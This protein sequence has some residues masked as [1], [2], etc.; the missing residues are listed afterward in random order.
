MMIMLVELIIVIIFH[1]YLAEAV[2]QFS[3]NS[4]MALEMMSTLVVCIDLVSPVSSLERSVVVEL[5][6]TNGTAAGAV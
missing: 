5:S 4:Y 1:P 3:L 2:F 6:T